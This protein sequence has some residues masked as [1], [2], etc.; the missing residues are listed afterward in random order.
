[1]LENHEPQASETTN[2]RASRLI[3]VDALRGLIMALMALDHA[4]H[5][6]AHKHPPGEYWGGGFP[7]Y[8]DALTFV[9][10]LVTHLAPSGFFLLMG[11]GMV[12]FADSRRRRGWSEWAIIKHFLARGAV[13]MALQLMLVNRAWELHP[14]GWGLEIYIGVLVALGG[15]MILGSLLL[16]I[17]P[18]YL[19][20]LTGLLVLGAELLTPDHS[21]WNHAYHAVTRVLLIPGG[22]PELWVNYPVLQWLELAMLG[23]ALGH[24]LAKDAGK[25]YRQALMAGVTLIA[26]FVVIRYLDGFG[27][28]R[29]RKG[30]DWIDFL[31]VVKYPPSIAYTLLTTGTNLI[32]LGLFGLASQ[33]VERFLQPLA[34]FGRTPL[35][36]YITHLFLYLGLGLL[37]A[38]NG[39]S[40]PLMYPFWLLGLLILYPLCLWYARFKQ[41][42][43]VG[44]VFRFL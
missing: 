32:I 7:V 12:L 40:I 14:S 31:N 18:K 43:P 25:A 39:T 21:Q 37:V 35:F 16:R 6:V 17:K 24:L 3:A 15:S 23:M 28:I 29:P 8:Y 27:N 19:L 34:T 26:A 20:A 10:R 44:S 38:P 30:N 11:L 33:K 4:N 41:R 2:H 13:L 22:S 9:T 5:F 36:F 1:M 42:R